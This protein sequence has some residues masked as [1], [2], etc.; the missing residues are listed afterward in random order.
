M[1]E[2]WRYEFD[3]LRNDY[4]CDNLGSFEQIY[5]VPAETED[6]FSLMENYSSLLQAAK[7]SYDDRNSLYGG[8]RNRKPMAA[9]AQPIAA[10]K[11]IKK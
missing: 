3:Q 6:Q 11:S 2:E 10:E 8:M 9:A 4:E 5:P 7:I 1:K